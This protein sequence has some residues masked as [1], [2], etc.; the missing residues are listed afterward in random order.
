MPFAEL[1]SSGGFHAPTAP[2]WSRFGAQAN[3][4]IAHQPQPDTAGAVEK[5]VGQIDEVMK[6]NS[7]EEKLKR[8]V[9]RLQL[10]TQ[11]KMY[12][13]YMVHPENYEVTAHGLNYKDKTKQLALQTSI[14][15]NVMLTKLA[16]SKMQPGSNPM[17]ALIDDAATKTGMRP[18]TPSR[19]NA[20]MNYEA[21]LP[22]NPFDTGE[23]GLSMSGD[24]GLDSENDSDTDDSGGVDI[25]SG[26]P[27]D[28]YG[29]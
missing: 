6:L 20:G 21:D 11:E 7:P 19:G 25:T 27:T 5:A 17:Q 13:D 29:P 15:K 22:D 18:A 24:D 28:I 10:A 14:A 2:D 9:Q 1:P 16:M 4:F 12:K 8:K 3:E 26:A 23:S